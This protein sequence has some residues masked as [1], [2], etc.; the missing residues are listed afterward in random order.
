MRL[1]AS[2]GKSNWAVAY[3]IGN[4]NRR[5]EHSQLVQHII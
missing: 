4:D 2:V 3:V 5:G 1:F